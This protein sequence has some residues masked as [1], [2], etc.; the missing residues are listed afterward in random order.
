MAKKV[1]FIV[2]NLC[3]SKYDYKEINKNIKIPALQKKSYNQNCKLSF[4]NR[5]NINTAFF[6]LQPQF[7]FITNKTP[8]SLK[9]HLLF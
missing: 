2:Y 9:N 5:S 6:L 1:N 8:L 4:N 3:L 7:C